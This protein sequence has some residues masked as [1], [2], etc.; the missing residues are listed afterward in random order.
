MFPASKKLRR[1]IC[2]SEYEDIRI[3]LNIDC[4]NKIP[5]KVEVVNLV[6]FHTTH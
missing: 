2:L 3:M 5:S 4:K 6:L 1:N